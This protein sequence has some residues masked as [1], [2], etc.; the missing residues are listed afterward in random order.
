MTGTKVLTQKIATQKG[1]NSISIALNNY[2]TSGTYILEV[3]N[4]TERSI[5][6]FIK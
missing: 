5:T 2:V 1:R 3:R 6:K 4:N